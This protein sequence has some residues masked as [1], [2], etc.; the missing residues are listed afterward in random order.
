[1][2]TRVLRVGLALSITMLGL[3]GLADAASAA[4]TVTLVCP[5]GS[6]RLADFELQ[7]GAY[8]VTAGAGA[9]SVTG[10]GDGGTFTLQDTTQVITAVLIAGPGG[11]VATKTERYPG[12]ITFGSFDASSFVPDAGVPASVSSVSFCGADVVLTSAQCQDE[13]VFDSTWDGAG[14]F[15]VTLA[16]TL[17]LCQ[18]VEFHVGTYSLDEP[19]GWDGQS[20][21]SA[22]ATPQTEFDHQLI[23]FGVLDEPGTRS[24]TAALPP[25]GPYQADLYRG[26]QRTSIDAS[27]HGSDFVRGGVL[28]G[29]TCAQSPGEPGTPG[30]GPT[31]GEPGGVSATAAAD[32]L[33]GV[34]VVTLTNGAAAATA[35]VDFTVDGAVYFVPAGQT[36]SLT[37]PVAQGAAYQVLASFPAR[38]SFPAGSE[39]FSGVLDCSEVNSGSSDTPPGAVGGEP[40][41]PG[42]PGQPGAESVAGEPGRATDGSAAPGDTPATGVSGSAASG[43]NRPAAEGGRFGG[44]ASPGQASAAGSGFLAATGGPNLVTGSLGTLALLA[45]GAALFLVRR[46]EQGEEFGRRRKLRQ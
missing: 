13:P 7:G 8:A 28:A 36:R 14:T 29:T 35:G 45:V 41:Q 37:F 17:A 10:A 32:C 3:P 1:M 44:A 38:G 19:E 24:A 15:S 34:L 27:G 40:G 31:G 5:D 4:S 18:A 6:S 12:G 21:L 26:A 11:P 46:P 2:T 42:Q 43:L 23:T 33:R 30:V 22:G 20:S 39:T 25:C 9:V 16:G